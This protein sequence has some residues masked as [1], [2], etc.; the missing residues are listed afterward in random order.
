[1]R[2]SLSSPSHPTP[3]PRRGPEG[4]SREYLASQ[5]WTADRV[6]EE[7]VDE[8]H[9]VPRY[10]FV[11]GELLASPSPEYLHRVAAREL[12]RLIDPY[13][14]AHGLG[15]VAW[16]PSDVAV[17][18]DSTAQPDLFV[19]L[20]EE[21]PRIRRRGHRRIGRLTLAVE[22]LSRSSRRATGW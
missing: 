15:E 16:S 4:F 1:M 7:L 19:V 12:F 20:A 14:R 8:C 17:A 5:R 9:P 21:V 6:R 11:G 10:E 3:D 2:M 13:V 18:P 22:I